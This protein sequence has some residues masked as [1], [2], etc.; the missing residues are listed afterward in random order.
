MYLKIR[1][2]NNRNIQ[3]KADEGVEADE[4]WLSMKIS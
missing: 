1:D 2:V 3:D 4:T